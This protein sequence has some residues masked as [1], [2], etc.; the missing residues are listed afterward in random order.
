MGQA[1]WQRC[2]LDSTVVGM[3]LP[4]CFSSRGPPQSATHNMAAGSPRVSELG[5]G[6]VAKMEATGL[7]W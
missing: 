2:D 4:P 7:P 5:E 1:F 3:L 6:E